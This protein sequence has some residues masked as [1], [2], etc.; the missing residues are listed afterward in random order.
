M[1]KILSI[2]MVFVLV[3]CDSSSKED[4]EKSQTNTGLSTEELNYQPQ[5]EEVIPVQPL[6]NSGYREV[7]WQ[8]LMPADFDYD[9]IERQINLDSYDIEALTDE[10]PEAQ[11]LLSDLQQVLNKIPMVDELDSE[12]ISIPGFAVPLEVEADRVFSFLLVP[13]FGACIHTPPPPANQTVYVEIEDGFVLPDLMTP[14]QVSGVIEVRSFDSGI[15]LA[16]YFIRADQV[17]LF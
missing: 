14:V 2:T 5:P 4:G 9:Q 10:D 3:A 15:G 8:E 12:P 16:G 6:Q 11:R 1:K 13:Y 7:D 17:E